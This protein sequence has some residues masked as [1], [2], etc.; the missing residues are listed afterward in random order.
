MLH[1]PSASKPSAG[2]HVVPPHHLGTNVVIM[3]VHICTCTRHMDVE[4]ADWGQQHSL[5]VLS[6]E[7]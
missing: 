3:C 6:A 2:V 7:C 4:L 1:T 5:E